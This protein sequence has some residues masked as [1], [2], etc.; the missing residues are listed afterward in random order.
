MRKTGL[1]LALSLLVAPALACKSS[2]PHGV[3]KETHYDARNSAQAMA[4][5]NRDQNRDQNR[6]AATD[7][8]LRPM[9]P[10]KER[11]SSGVSTERF[12]SLWAQLDQV[13]SKLARDESLKNKFDDKVDGIAND[14]AKAQR[15]ATEDDSL[16]QSDIER[17][18]KSL[19]E[20][21]LDLSKIEVEVGA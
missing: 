8:D 16:S 19:A 12:R 10:A 14:L 11:S 13:R 3:G 17:L 18:D 6:V 20:I 15:D 5:E 1:M 4:Y 7:Q 21:Q 2:S 9:T